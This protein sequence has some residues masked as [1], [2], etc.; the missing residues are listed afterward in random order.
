MINVL[1]IKEKGLKCKRRLAGENEEYIDKM[2]LH[3]I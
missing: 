1:N 2:W 3:Y